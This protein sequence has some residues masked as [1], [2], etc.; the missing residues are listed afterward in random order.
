MEFRR[1]GIAI[2]RESVFARRVLTGLVGA[3][4]RFKEQGF[5]FDLRFLYDSLARNKRELE[6]FDGFIAQ[7]QN[8]EM[9]RALMSTGKPVVDVLYKQRYENCAVVNPD[10]RAISRLVVEHLLSR[11]FRH[12]AFCGREG[13][14]YSDERCRAFKE[15]LAD[16]G[17]EM[18][19]YTLA[20]RAAHEYF[21]GK[22]PRKELKVEDPLD[23]VSLRRWVKQLS[24]GTAVFC[25]QDLRAYQLLRISKEEGIAIPNQIALIG[26]DDDPIFCHF[27]TPRLSSVDPHAERV[28]HE[29]LALL[30]TAFTEGRPLTFADSRF[31]APRALSVRE[32]SEV[33]GYDPPWLGEA[34]AYI[35]RHIAENLSAEDVYRTLGK[36]HTVVDRYFRKALGTS[37]QK[38]IIKT[39]L[40]RA[41]FLLKTTD[42]PIKM[43]LRQSGFASFSYFCTSFSRFYGMSAEAYREKEGCGI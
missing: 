42:A 21:L 43:I 7:V 39:R 15:L 30:A 13:V 35:Y 10:N 33:F 9:G 41:A 23:A 5:D 11:R 32:S 22:D 3:L 31:I 27:T 4:P 40:E 34:L 2:E 29:A 25:C 20:E 26:V 17:F 19:P 24:S 14:F 36:S 38:I 16:A 6:D 1:I 37:V 28:G 12:F 8:P 18:T